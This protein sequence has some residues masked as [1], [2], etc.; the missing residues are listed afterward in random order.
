MR[1]LV[2]VV[3]GI[4]ALLAT[5]SADPLD[6]PAFTATPA[7]L[8]AAAKA[9]PSV[10]D[11]TML[12]EDVD[13][14]IDDQGRLTDRWRMVFVVRTQSA[15]SDWDTVGLKYRPTFQDH[16]IVRARV[17]DPAGRVVDLDAKLESDEPS[18]KE[19]GSVSDSR[20]LSAPLPKLVVGSVVE[21][22]VVT[23]DREASSGA[24]RGT[25]FSVGRGNLRLRLAVP[26][27]MKPR[28]IERA[29]GSNHPKHEI[30]NGTESWTYTFGAVPVVEAESDLP[31][32]V[33][34]SPLIGISTIPTWAALARD[35]S[36]RVDQQIAAGPVAWP[37]E[38]PKAATIE[39]TRAIVAWL[40]GHV[41]A[42]NI[43]VD[44]A[45]LLPAT[46][47]ATVK[48][49]AADDLAMAV[50]L[51]ALL[52]QAGIAANVALI[53]LG[54]GID[55]DPD[56]PELDRFDHAIV[57]A[58]LGRDVWIDPTA[59]FYPVGR[60][61]SGSEGRRALVLA[62]T[63]S[64]LITTP[65]SAATDNGV[66][67]V[68]TYELAELG[69]A[70][71]TETRGSSGS[72]EVDAREAF[73]GMSAAE[74][75]AAL[76]DE[77]KTR[78]L[79]D[80]LESY[81]VGDPNDLATPFTTS[82]AVKES[83]RANSKREAIDVYLTP[84][85]V[86]YGL[87]KAFR[88][89]KSERVHDFV[90]PAPYVYEVENRLVVPEGF[91]MPTIADR[92]IDAGIAKLT[93]TERISGRTMIVTFRFESGKQR[94]TPVEVMKTRAA[95]AAARDEVVHLEFPNT[96]R[97][98]ADGG[99]PREAIAEHER[100]IKL[101]PTHGRHHADLAELY[102]DLGILDAARREARKGIELERDSA[103]MHLTLGW[104][105]AHDDV[106]RMY[107][108]DH[109]HAGA[110][111]ELERARQLDPKHVGAAVE[112]GKLLEG[113]A[114]GR[115][116]EPGADLRGAAKAWRAA[117]DLSPSEFN[118]DG[119]MRTLLWTSDFAEAAKFGRTLKS[120]PN[121]DALFL[122]AV[123]VASG[124]PAA[125][126]E[127]NALSHD[128]RAR[129]LRAAAATLMMM[130]H[131]DEMRAVFAELGTLQS[132]STEAQL[133]A[134]VQRRDRPL[135][136][137]TPEGAAIE[138][139]LDI[140]R[141]DKSTGYW[142]AITAEEVGDSLRKG[143][144]A[145]M[146]KASFPLSVVADMTRSTSNAHVEGDA[147][148]WRIDFDTFGTHSFV[149]AAMDRGTIKVIGGTDAPAGV[150]RHALRLLAKHDVVRAQHCLDWVA[151][152]A[153]KTQFFREVWGPNHGTDRESI[154]VAAAVLA[155][156]TDALH[157]LPI[158]K[159]CAGATAVGAS[160]CTARASEIFVKREAWSELDA[161]ATAVLVTRPDDVYAVA[162]KAVA[163]MHLG[164]VKDAEA[165][166]DDRLKRNPD[167]YLL[168][169]ERIHA[170]FAN[171]ETADALQRAEALTKR[172]T[173]PK[174]VNAIDHNNLAWLELLSN[175]KLADALASAR[176]ATRLAPS[177]TSAFET[178]AAIEAELGDLRAAH[179]DDLAAM[180][181]RA[182]D[183][184]TGDDWYV[185][186]RIAEQLGLRD[187][188]IAAYRR[189]KPRSKNPII[190]GSFDLAQRRLAVLGKP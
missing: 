67:E 27:K 108:H 74:V 118:G 104:V 42:T 84:S 172:T 147:S 14:R 40:H 124:V 175:T 6:K 179:D 29:I 105:L 134:K 163:A 7:E 61:A 48:L 65:R 64:A 25:V 82:L 39:S 86:F 132:G 24:G 111:T 1:G 150:G 18:T 96:A 58:Q 160:M 70:H 114:Q 146:R 5:A 138:A 107:G 119:V 52:R 140:T 130:R 190:P 121:R 95:I 83:G 45:P 165:L 56:L 87:P 69:Y 177:D 103:D 8:L 80:S 131:Y 90:W 2:L 133:V 187:D 125:I 159:A 151:Q 92:T 68:R 176:E 38:V 9:A 72:R 13:E 10:D 183:T 110:R 149:Y 55:V 54:P 30:V 171:N 37:A 141:D 16:P 32:D 47:A 185:S 33:T 115:P 93:E 3:V 75:K 63:T 91:S 73:A 76:V 81:T 137:K 88:D 53:D 113:D 180:R 21:E 155:G 184:P 4:S 144:S 129:A 57:H 170:S 181:L 41:A 142:D 22:E 31:G 89:E 127:A 59:V 164:A 85:S 19:Q 153:P 188:A 71:V 120:S 77:V 26:A 35:L 116:H 122:T 36:A 62:T 117:Y 50:T 100:L 78:Y 169:A 102:T 136:R 49:G 167:D 44:D 123:S 166:L 139:A 168:L 161:Y 126:R 79:V 15:A 174:N 28:H 109:D 128:A 17:I 154:E 60:T 101:H 51:V 66:H 143:L 135:D 112:L 162:S 46:P 20:E 145:S 152:D 34:I 157:S 23:I 11:I 94:L 173:S 148:A 189:V 156:E 106:G 158:L 98:L 12:R 178:L 182:H 43:G 186:G 99:K 97:Q